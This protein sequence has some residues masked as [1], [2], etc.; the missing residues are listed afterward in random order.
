MTRRN[1][2]RTAL[3]LYGSETGNAQNIAEEIGRVLERLRFI[4]RVSELNTIGVVR[5]RS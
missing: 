4:T 3:V 5:C 2:D 1:Q